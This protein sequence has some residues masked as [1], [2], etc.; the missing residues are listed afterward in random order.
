MPR[1]FLMFR[2]IEYDFWLPGVF[3]LGAKNHIENRATSETVWAQF[4]F[5]CGKFEL[6]T[7]KIV[8]SDICPNKYLKEVLRILF[9][10]FKNYLVL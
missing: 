9:I 5:W 8:R 10:Y 1:L 6:T 3:F 4:V 2:G 7:I